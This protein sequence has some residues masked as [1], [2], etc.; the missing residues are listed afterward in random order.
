MNVKVFLYVLLFSV[1]IL[2]FVATEL[3]FIN[4]KPLVITLLSSISNSNVTESVQIVTPFSGR[5]HHAE[6]FARKTSRKTGMFHHSSPTPT[7]QPAVML[8][9]TNLARVSTSKS[10][11]HASI[12]SFKT[13]NHRLD[14]S[15]MVSAGNISQDTLPSIDLSTV[16]IPTDLCPELPPKLVGPLKVMKEELSFKEIAAKNPGLRPGGLFSPPSCASRHRVAIVIPYRKRESHLKI[17]LN[18]LHP[19]LQRQQLEYGVYVIDQLLPGKFNRALLM[20][21]GF[22]EAVK[23]HDYQC[24]VFHDVDLIPENDNNIY[25]CP[26]QPRHMSIAVDKWNYKLLY[27]AIF[28]GVSALSVDHFRLING[29]SNLYF[30][31]GGEDDDIR[32][33]IIAKG[34]KVIRY[35]ME[36]G[37]YT[38]IKHEIDATNPRNPERYPLL[39]NARERMDNDGLN[40]LYQLYNITKVDLLPTHTRIAVLLDDSVEFSYKTGLKNISKEVENSTYYSSTVHPST[41][42]PSNERKKNTTLT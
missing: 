25:S 34:L 29:F 10:F 42:H 18:N 7:S 5:V 30:G 39:K 3:S 8:T 28:G 17:L 38:M 40:T 4:P 35:P 23:R 16:V 21:I 22:L 20:N 37:R 31:W 14:N 2:F 12:P 33:R 15:S 13:S 32:K 11:S 36:V 27:G 6:H 24:V 26:L 41:I 19:M 9:T 1:V